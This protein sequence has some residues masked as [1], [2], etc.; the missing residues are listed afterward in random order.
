MRYHA[1]LLF[2]K[3]RQCT[4]AR[5]V[6]AAKVHASGELQRKSQIAVGLVP[7]ATYLVLNAVPSRR[8]EMCFIQLASPVTTMV[9]KGRF[10]ADSE[11]ARASGLFY[12]P[13]QPR[14]FW[15]CLEDFVSFFDRIY[16]VRNLRDDVGLRAL[17]E[18][19]TTAP[20]A[21]LEG[22][23]RFGV[24]NPTFL[25][26]TSL[27]SAEV[28]LS[29]SQP[30]QRLRPTAGISFPFGTQIHVHDWG[31]VRSA[32][33]PSCTDNEKTT[34]TERKSFCVGAFTDDPGDPLVYK[35]SVVYGRDNAV[36]LTLSGDRP[37]QITVSSTGD[38]VETTIAV[39]SAQRFE[40]VNLGTT[41]EPFVYRE[42]QGRWQG[43]TAGGNYHNAEA[44]RFNPQVT[45][46]FGAPLH[47][48]ANGG[49]VEVTV[50]LTQQCTALPQ[51]YRIGLIGHFSIDPLN[52]ERPFENTST[53]EEDAFIEVP[54]ACSRTVAKTFVA[55]SD[56]KGLT[57]MPM[58][59][60]AGE[61]G[62]WV[63]GCV[64]PV[65][66]KIVERRMDL[67]L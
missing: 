8:G 61:E 7:N 11:D 15:M 27:R 57:V 39:S 49:D 14:H 31:A 28:L 45:I 9:W 25:L 63:L 55:P 58:T 64:A 19:A 1:P 42:L 10:G 3:I 59:W 65:D 66:F 6:V 56:A 41:P 50:S 5:R 62:D 18:R 44:M 51:A 52:R 16:V 38:S 4:I 20:R 21:A 29:V 67:R 30:D 47:P 46:T 43:I 13:S 35:S 24:D 32:S 37:L 33:G 26:R 34:N 2:D 60:G 54:F 48:I 23:S 17:R 53:S 40:M 36:P 12:T 22:T